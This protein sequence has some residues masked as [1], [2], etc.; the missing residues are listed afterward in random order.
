M[1]GWA[2]L[3]AVD[4]AAAVRSG[5]VAARDVVA[6]HLDRIGLVNDGLGAFVRVRAAAALA[7]AEAVDRRPDRGELRL[8][9]VP[10][11]VK[12][13]VPV[14][15]E[16]MRMGSR[17]APDVPQP[18]DHPVVRRLR[19]AG[20]VVVGVTSMP[21]LALYPFTD[22]AFGVA[23]N[24]WNT[25]RTP[26]GSSGGSA[27]A[28]AAGMVPVAHGNDGLGSI[29]IP[30]ACCGLIGVKPGPGVV[31]A[32]AGA[33]GW[34]GLLENG[35]LA[36]TAADAAL[37]LGVMAG[38]V[39]DL[40]PPPRLRVAVSVKPTGPGVAIHRGLKQVT[41]ECGDVLAGLGHVVSRAD[42][43][44]PAWVTP[45]LVGRWLAVAVSEMSCLE[46]D[47]T[48][49]RTRRHARA[50]RLVLRVRPP[51]A[52]SRLRLRDALDPFFDRHDLLVMPSLAWPCPPARRWG[53]GS[54]LRSVIAALRF[55]PM[56][57]IWSLAGFPAVSVPAGMAAGMPGS[58]QLVAGPGQEA[59]LLAVAAELELSAGWRR[60]APDYD[61]AG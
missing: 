32:G 6:E 10:V 40:A 22:S 60:H 59:L 12:D 20:A 48:E 43:R 44:Y 31:P 58:V 21:E 36:T 41:R 23:R 5:E 35:P 26:G 57:G 17:A 33:G 45:E 4:I 2:G 51:Q 46:G 54:W 11:A 19:E 55:A 42:P 1:A 52:G 3:S 61:P 53:E 9:G 28:V 7:E 14:A 47:G 13:N 30:A 15:G 18:Q 38:T 16:P 24:P 8:A 39:Y 56:T 34:D 50:G 29:R 37:M 25:L 49:R 27:A